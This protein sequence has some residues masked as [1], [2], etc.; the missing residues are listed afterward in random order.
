MRE[1]SLRFM[2]HCLFPAHF[3]PLSYQ[4][5]FLMRLKRSHLGVTYFSSMSLFFI[6]AEL[7]S[8]PALRIYNF[9][10]QIRIWVYLFL[11]SHSCLVSAILHSSLLIKSLLIVFVPPPPSFCSYP[12]SFLPL[13]TSVLR[14]SDSAI[15]AVPGTERKSVQTYSFYSAHIMYFLHLNS[16]F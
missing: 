12:A 9:E 16:R 14:V 1:Q 13:S 5:I 4:Q 8:N 2:A 7:F 10:H 6:W 15:S 11:P 3:I